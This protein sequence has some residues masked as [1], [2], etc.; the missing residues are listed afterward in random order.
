MGTRI[1]T[2]DGYNN[3]EGAVL[4]NS[5]TGWAFG[6]VFESG[7]QAEAF[8]QF[9]SED[10]KTMTNKELEEAYLRFLPVWKYCG[11]DEAETEHF[12]ALEHR[13]S[14][15]RYRLIHGAETKMTWDDVFNLDREI[16]RLKS[17]IEDARNEMWQL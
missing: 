16:S 2:T 14:N 13:R 10:P 11:L 7:E 15:G 12:I 8:T 1:L 9:V 4:F 3:E 5:T 6:P 17:K